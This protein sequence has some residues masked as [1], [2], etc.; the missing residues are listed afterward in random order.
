VEVRDGSSSGS[1]THLRRQ[2]Q[3][4]A[5]APCE[6]R[7]ATRSGRRRPDG[8]GGVR[9]CPWPSSCRSRLGRRIP[10]DRREV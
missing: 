6:R 4:H 5:G 10:W 9:S 2:A 8:L 1:R 7:R 3:R